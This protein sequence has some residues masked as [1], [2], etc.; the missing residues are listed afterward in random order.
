M[1]NLE[2][3]S[4]HWVVNDRRNIVMGEGRKKILE[5]IERTGSINK[6]AKELKMSYKGVWSRIRV[7]EDHLKSRLVRSDGKRGSQ[8]T[9]EAKSLLQKYSRLKDEC[10]EADDRVFQA[11]FSR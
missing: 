5:A 2:M 3:R 11:I 6:A 4:R 9:E 8:L 1:L 7:T 10:T